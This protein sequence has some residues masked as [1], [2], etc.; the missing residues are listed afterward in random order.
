MSSTN[1]ECLRTRRPRVELHNQALIN[2]VPAETTETLVRIE[3]LRKLHIESSEAGS[4]RPAV[5]QPSLNRHSTV[6]Q[7][8]RSR[9]ATDGQPSHSRISTVCLLYAV[10]VAGGMKT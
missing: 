3:V 2:P 9:T 10:S 5:A 7:S 4:R 6:T 1:L 8:S